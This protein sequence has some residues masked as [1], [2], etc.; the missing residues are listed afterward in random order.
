M[1]IGILSLVLSTNYGGIIQAYALQTIL[2][3]MGHEVI[4]LNKDRNMYLSAYRRYLSACKYFIFKHLR[5]KNVAYFNPQQVNEKRIERE[6]NTQQFIDKYIHTRVVKEIKKGILEDVDCIIVGSDQ[7]WRPIYFNKLWGADI[8]DAYLRFVSN[9]KIRKY[10]YAAS[11]GTDEWEYSASE[12]I[13]CSHLLK[14]FSAVS[15]RESSAIQLCKQ[16]LSREDVH[17]V[18]DPS[19][20]LEKE[21]YIKLINELDPPKSPGNLMCYILDETPEKK[22]LINTIGLKK[23]LTPFYTNSKVEDFNAPQ[24]ERVQPPLENW[25][26]GFIDAEFVITDSYHACI[27][28]IIFNKPF[29]VVGNKKRGISRFYS[30]LDSLSLSQNIILSTEDYDG[31]FSYEI[32]IESLKKCHNLKKLSLKFLN[33]HFKIH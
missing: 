8:P 24:T 3:R 33:D 11:F 32:P 27:F 7:V 21:D 13:K 6:K 4:V 1:K 14:D 5:K 20:L 9:K 16:K 12:T 22:R 25:L 18:L 26:R 29:V 23:G 17:L 15:V 31:A 2:E 30:L 10:A 19:F 28:S